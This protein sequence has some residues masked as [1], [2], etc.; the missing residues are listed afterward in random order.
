MAEDRIIDPSTVD[1]GLP[2]TQESVKLLLEKG[3]DAKAQASNGRGAIS[4][5]ISARNATVIQLLL[6]HDAPKKPLALSAAADCKA[7]LDLLLPLGDEQDLGGALEGAFL[8]GNVSLVQKLLD[9]GAKPR[10]DLLQATAMSPAPVPSEMVRALISRG[11]KVD[12][13]T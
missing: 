3:A 8:A 11:A 2:L 5:A 1:P 12:S 6:Q 13:K 7:C 10:P 4:F 9:R